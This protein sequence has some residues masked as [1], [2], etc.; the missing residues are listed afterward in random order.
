MSTATSTGDRFTSRSVFHLRTAVRWLVTGGSVY[1]FSAAT[2]IHHCSLSP[3]RPSHMSETEDSGNMRSRKRDRSLS[4]SKKRRRTTETTEEVPEPGPA[5]NSQ[6]VVGPILSTSSDFRHFQRPDYSRSPSDVL[7][8][9][10][11]SHISS[12]IRLISILFL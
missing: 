8:A 5:V 10:C 12:V 6:S 7:M 2:T 1:G 9:V 3:N 4:L 11:K